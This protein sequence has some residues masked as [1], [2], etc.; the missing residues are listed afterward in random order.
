MPRM[1]GAKLRRMKMP[2]YA[3]DEEEDNTSESRGLQSVEPFGQFTAKVVTSCLKWGVTGCG[4][5][6]KM[7]KNHY[8]QKSA[9]LC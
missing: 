2:L 3:H 7:G 4:K 9:E 5:W 8:V 1:Q 6:L